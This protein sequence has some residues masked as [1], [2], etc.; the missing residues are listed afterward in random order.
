MAS[1]S[2]NYNRSATTDFQPQQQPQQSHQAQE[3]VPNLSSYETGP[4]NNT[5]GPHQSDL[6]NKLDP[7]VDSDL[8]N[9]AQYAPGTTT[10]SNSHPGATSYAADPQAN[11]TLGPHEFDIKNKFDPRVNSKTGEMTTKTT[12]RDGT[13]P[14]KEPVNQGNNSTNFDTTPTTTSD[15]P[16]TGSSS[17][18][19]TSSS[20]KPSTS[21]GVVGG[22]STGAPAVP[23]PVSTPTGYDREQGSYNPAT[24]TGYTPT[25]RE[26]QQAAT[27]PA[28]VP[29]AATTAGT[30]TT[31]T[32]TGADAGA[33]A[34]GS[35]GAAGGIKGVVAGI[36]GAGESIRGTFNAAVDRAFN[37]PEG[38]A[39]NEAIG[40][41]GEY[42]ARSGQFAPSTKQ[43][44][45]FNTQNRT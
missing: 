2:T 1:S 32:G 25:H 6:A 10:T 41:E 7:R 35:K 42:E 45:G 36:H 39:K 29:T 11:N 33:S 44:E 38:V 28:T 9:R 22:S 37:E 17:P 30:R 13:G 27:Q 15:Y 4:A 20:T 24:G 23:S 16:T 26:Q 31:D 18:G 19:H 21:G 12:N 14:R 5:A 8:N 43:R 40:R 34:S 3:S